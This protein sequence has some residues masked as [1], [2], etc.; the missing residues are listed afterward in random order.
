M[1]EF[2]AQLITKRFN[3][4]MVEC[5]YFDFVAEAAAALGFNRYMVECE[6]LFRM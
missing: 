1:L 5:E 6:L 2:G 3:R 4:Y